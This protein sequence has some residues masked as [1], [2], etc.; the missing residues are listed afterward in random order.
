[1][2]TE[3]ISTYT[4]EYMDWY[5]FESDIPWLGVE[6]LE[7]SNLWGFNKI[8]WDIDWAYSLISQTDSEIRLLVADTEAWLQTSITQNS[9]SITLE[10]TNRTNADNALSASITVEANRITQEVTDR[11]NADNSLSASITV[12][13]NRITSE[14]TARQNWDNVLQS[15]ITQ[16]AG[17]I[18]QEITDRTNADNVLQSSI[19]QTA[20]EIALRVWDSSSTKASVVVWAINWWTV[21]I[22]AKNI[23]INGTTTFSSGYDPTTK[24]TPI[25]AQAKVDTLSS[26]LWSLAYDDLVW[27]AKLDTTVI[28]WGFI[29]TNLLTANNIVAWTFTGLTFRTS[30]S[31]QRVELSSSDNRINVYD[32]SG[33]N[34][35]NIW[36]S[37]PSWNNNFIYWLSGASWS[38]PLMFLQSARNTNIA[39]LISWVNS[40]FA[41]LYIDSSGNDRYCAEFHNRWVSSNYAQILLRCTSW[42]EAIDFD[43]IYLERVWNDLFWGNTQIN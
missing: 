1:M 17:R 38:W 9:Q 43:W 18:T 29:K 33:T 21:K 37:D 25:W 35:L 28:D 20:S 4:P 39:R 19:T 6:S 41:A 30:S 3:K 14:V 10:A 12:E 42:N 31:W 15:N 11:T 8:V 26:S 24:E 5:V 32:T 16:E 40:N 22:E 36:Y 7:A 23:Q 34:V 27:V 2:P 13:A